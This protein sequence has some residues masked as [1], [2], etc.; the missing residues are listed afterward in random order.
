MIIANVHD[1]KSQLSKLL[2]AAERGEDVFITRRGSGV[3]RF[4]ISPAPAIARSALF[5][6]L[7]SEVPSD[8]DFD[9]AD[10]ALSESLQASLERDL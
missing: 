3:T 10:R 4:R 8:I 5:G 1:S 9:A 7:A 2:D 6:M